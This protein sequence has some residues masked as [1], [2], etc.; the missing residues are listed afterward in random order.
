M[1]NEDYKKM[2]E[3]YANYWI[4]MATT[5]VGNDKLVE[6]YLTVAKTHIRNF[7][8]AAEEYDDDDEVPLYK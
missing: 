2:C 3:M 1:T 7:V 4:A 6:E 8:E 5:G